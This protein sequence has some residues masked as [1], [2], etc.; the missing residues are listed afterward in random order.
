MLDNCFDDAKVSKK[1][2]HD[3]FNFLKWMILIDI[4]VNFSTA[5]VA[6][7]CRLLHTLTNDKKACMNWS[8]FNSERK[9]FNQRLKKWHSFEK[10][11]LHDCTKYLVSLLKEQDFDV[12]YMLNTE[13][14]HSSK[15]KKSSL[16]FFC[17]FCLNKNIFD[18]WFW[19]CIWFIC[20]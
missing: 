2:G 3:T 20:L 13:S 6:W 19:K 14:D 4:Q 12:D 9:N 10:V 15:K 17:S 7:I 1:T 5:A 16:T 11:F 18:I 8:K